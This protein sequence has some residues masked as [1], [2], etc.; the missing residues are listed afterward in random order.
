MRQS[1]RRLPN[2]IIYIVVEGE[3][4]AAILVELKGVDVRKA[5][6]Q[7]D[8]TLML[9][10]KFFRSCSNVYGRIVVSSLYSSS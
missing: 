4:P 9:F 3:R 5:M 1:R 2:V 10:P 6:G 7:I 8:S